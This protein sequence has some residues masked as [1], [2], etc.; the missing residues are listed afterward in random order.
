MTYLVSTVYYLLFLCLFWWFEAVLASYRFR[1][2]LLLR[3]RQGG[4]FQF[5]RPVPR[6]KKF[7]L[8]IDKRPLF[9][10]AFEIRNRQWPFVNLE[11]RAPGVQ[12]YNCAFNGRV[13]W[14]MCTRVFTMMRSEIIETKLPLGVGWRARIALLLNWNETRKTVLGFRV[15]FVASRSFWAG[16]FCFSEGAFRTGMYRLVFLL[17]VGN[18]GSDNM[19]KW[20][21][22]IKRGKGTISSTQ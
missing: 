19:L 10:S 21:Q 1:G 12:I 20:P 16:I 11:P 18:H 17:G 7:Q 22:I 3:E 6:S 14:W 15:G 13:S 9:W 4:T 5:G 8:K 2:F